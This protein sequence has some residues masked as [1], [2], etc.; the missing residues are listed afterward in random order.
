MKRVLVTGATGCIG[1]HA[2][3]ELVTHGWEVHAVSSRG[4]A[5]N[6]DIVWHQADLLDPQQVRLVTKRAR[7]SHLLHLAWYI[8]PG[9]WASAPE[10]FA[11]VQASLELLHAFQRDGGTRVVTAGSCLEYDWNYGYCS[12]IRTPCAPHT[13]YGVCKHALQMLTSAF[14]AGTDLTSAWGRVFFLYGPYEHPERLVASVVRSL[15]SGEP[16][17][18]SHG[19]QIR[20]YLF[21]QDVADAFVALL[22]SNL[23]GPVNIASGQPVALKDIVTRIGSL[24]GRADLI[25]LG[26][27]PAAPTDTPLVVADIT[28]LRDELGWR[29]R[30]SLDQGLEPTIAWWRSRM[31]AATGAGPHP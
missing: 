7:A 20:D 12:E 30:W 19:N 3:P 4:V 11:W 2:L 29:P 16:A 28:R 17:R 18:C 14:T 10:N 27:I 15:L 13:A 8:A 9:R 26:A 1:R 23:T 31:P 21:A 22:D 6:A 5:E 24:V 25:R